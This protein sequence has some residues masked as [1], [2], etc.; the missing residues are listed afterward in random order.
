MG[1]GTTEFRLIDVL[2]GGGAVA[3]FCF[4]K[5]ENGVVDSGS[6]FGGYFLWCCCVVMCSGGGAAW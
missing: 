6:A 2:E 3:G 5:V 4:Q 1:L